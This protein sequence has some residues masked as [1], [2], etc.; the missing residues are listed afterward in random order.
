M[1]IYKYVYVYIYAYIYIY[2]Y[3]YVYTYTYTYTLNKHISYYTIYNLFGCIIFTC[4]S[5]ASFF[6][7]TAVIRMEFAGRDGSGSTVEVSYDWIHVTN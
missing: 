4:P 5:R 6:G 3:T 2:I 1:Y 7:S